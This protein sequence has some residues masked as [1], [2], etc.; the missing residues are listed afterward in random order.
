MDELLR[1]DGNAAAVGTFG[2]VF[3]FE[4][5]MA[6]YACGGCEDRSDRG[7]DGLGGEGSGHDRSLPWLRQ[8]P[9]P[10][11]SRPRAVLNRSEGHKVPRARSFRSPMCA[12]TAPKAR[13][14]NSSETPSW[15]TIAGS[16]LSTCSPPGSSSR[17]DGALK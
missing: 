9:R 8:R 13:S 11:R 3:S 17:I 2:E 5:T 12:A 1:L 7:G 14:T 4:V 16:T 15:S 10:P 6:E